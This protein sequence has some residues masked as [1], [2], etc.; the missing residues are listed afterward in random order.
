MDMAG[1]VWEWVSDWYGSDYYCKGPVAC[2]SPNPQWTY[3]GDASAYSSPWTDPQGPG[4]GHLRIIRGGSGGYGNNSGLKTFE[5]Q[6]DVPSD[7]PYIIGARCC[8]SL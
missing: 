4:S 8:R 6:E 1:N 2:T 5:R 3:C 7:S